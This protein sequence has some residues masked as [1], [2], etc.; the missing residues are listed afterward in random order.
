M[1]DLIFEMLQSVLIVIL[2]YIFGKVGKKT[3]T[4]EQIEAK[5]EAKKQKYINKQMKKNNITPVSTQT[6]AETGV[7][8][9]QKLVEEIKVIENK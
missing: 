5:G 4:A 7:S 2:G 1:Q 9:V 3:K 6:S 8:A